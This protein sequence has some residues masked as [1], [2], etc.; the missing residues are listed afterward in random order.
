MTELSSVSLTRVD[1]ETQCRADQLRSLDLI[2]FLRT[3]P[4]GAV[5]LAPA[6]SQ[7]QSQEAMPGRLILSS[8]FLPQRDQGKGAQALDY[9]DILAS[10]CV[11]R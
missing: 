1:R 2:E 3:F 10:P 4:A 6:L 9:K 5:A 7:I 8:D 11:R